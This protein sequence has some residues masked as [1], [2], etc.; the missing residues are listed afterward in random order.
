MRAL[1]IA[2]PVQ[3]MLGVEDRHAESS[4]IWPSLPELNRQAVLTQ[5][6][7]LIRSGSLRDEPGQ[8]EEVIR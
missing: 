2:V 7:R 5:L 4:A 3:L 8:V 1:R 6:A